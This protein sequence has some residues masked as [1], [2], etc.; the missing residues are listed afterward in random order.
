MQIKILL[1]I[2]FCLNTV[3]AANYY[4]DSAATGNYSGTSWLNAWT[5]LNQVSGLTAGDTVYFSGGASN[6]RK[7]YT[8]S[9][10]VELPGAWIPS[11]GTEGNPI[12]YRISSEV[13]HNGYAVFQGPGTN[14]GVNYLFAYQVSPR[15]HDIIISGDAGDGL[16]HFIVTNYY[17]GGV[18]EGYKNVRISYMNFGMLFGGFEMNPVDGIEFDH[19]FIH[20]FGPDLDH[21]FLLAT[22]NFTSN[23]HLFHNNVSIAPGRSD[24]IG[25]DNLAYNGGGLNVFSNT[26]ITF[27]TNYTA[28]QHMDGVVSGGAVNTK[29]FNNTFIN[30]SDYALYWAINTVQTNFGVYNLLF[31]N[32]R[33]VNCGGSVIVG[34]DAAGIG[35]YYS[36]ICIFN[37]TIDNAT[38]STAQS[39]G[40]G[41]GAGYANVFYTNCI[42][43]NNLIIGGTPYL[44]YAEAAA[45]TTTNANQYIT[46]AQGTTN[47]VDYN[48]SYGFATTNSDLRPLT[49]AT[50]IVD[51]GDNLSQYFTNDF[52]GV[53]RPSIAAWDLGAYESYAAT[54]TPIVIT[55]PHIIIS[56]PEKYKTGLKAMEN[57]NIN[58]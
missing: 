44:F 35:S 46:Q 58:R 19:N 33:F 30:V 28:G 32:N 47:F 3:S 15:P 1:T 57:M 26:F 7:Y 38:N 39:F 24:S 20:T 42:A 13:G 25:A 43:K 37:N 40:M 12:S 55:V 17:I 5:N 45:G 50:L 54:N 4:I 23:R 34:T 51:R 27:F 31:Y 49:T 22:T 9:S 18:C 36:N 16:Q 8:G 6:Q 52:L 56:E 2:L 10:I 48:T 29:V 21:V 14:S 53:A 11:S 41:G